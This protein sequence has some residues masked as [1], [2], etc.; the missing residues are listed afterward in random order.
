[1]YTKTIIGAIM[2]DG[3]FLKADQVAYGSPSFIP[4]ASNRNQDA[5]QSDFSYVLERNNLLDEFQ[6]TMA[7]PAIL[8]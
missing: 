4:E 3:S 8:F 6:K 5:N 2:L 7:K 1:M